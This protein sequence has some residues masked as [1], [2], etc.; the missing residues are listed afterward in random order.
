M[1]LLGHMV[2]WFL[3]W[4]ISLHFSIVATP[5]FSITK[6]ALRF[7]FIPCPCQHVICWLHDNSYSDWCEVWYLIV[8]LICISLKISGVEHL[9]ILPL[10]ICMSALVKCLSCHWP[11]FYWIIYLFIYLF[12]VIELYE[13][14]IYFEF[15]PLIG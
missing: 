9:F 7:P 11:I 3:L 14:L 6:G 15:Q 10:A 8:V 12:I 1:K 2:D 4:E 13:F 5:I